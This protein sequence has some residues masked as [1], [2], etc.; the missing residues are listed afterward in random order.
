[1]KNLEQFK[2]VKNFNESSL[3]EKNSVFTAQIFPI[4]NEDVAIQKLNE[5]KKKLYDAN[6][7]C[8]AYKLTNGVFKY[9]DDGEPSGT[10]GIRILNAIEHF[11]LLNIL[12]IV[13]RY[14]GGTKL[15]VGPLGKAYYN[16]ALQ[17]LENSEIILKIAYRKI[18][19]KSDFDN[20]SFVHKAMEKFDG[21]IENIKY[22]NDAT[23]ECLIKNEKIDSIKLFLKEASNGKINI[24][25][26]NDILYL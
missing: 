4:K 6:H 2:T 24:T 19:V 7:H 22:E 13:I 8:F 14:F 12:I 23:F 1:M 16:S 26:K 25:I 18:F 20:I 3:K 5:I 17:V 11:E 15:G 9:S 21:K 10:A